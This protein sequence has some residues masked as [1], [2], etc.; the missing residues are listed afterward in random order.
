MGDQQRRRTA[1]ELAFFEK[2]ARAVLTHDVTPPSVVVGACRNGPGLHHLG[3]GSCSICDW[4]ELPEHVDRARAKAQ[5][6]LDQARHK[7]AAIEAFTR[8]PR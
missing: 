3:D 4:V 5:A 7:L 2:Q 6:E 1:L 8:R